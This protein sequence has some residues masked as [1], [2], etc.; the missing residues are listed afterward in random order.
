[1]SSAVTWQKLGMGHAKMTAVRRPHMTF[2]QAAKDDV[3]PA[4]RQEAEIHRRCGKWWPRCWYTITKGK[5]LQSAQQRMRMSY[6][7]KVLYVIVQRS[8]QRLDYIGHQRVP[9]KGVARRN[10]SFQ[11]V[12]KE[13][14]CKKISV[15]FKRF[16]SVSCTTEQIK[17]IEFKAFPCR[18]F[19]TVPNLKK[20]LWLWKCF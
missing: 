16:N 18:F 8:C 6:N 14:S 12:H 19:E 10:F 4:I 5:R 11:W 20:M 17:E 13:R 1:M 9:Q 15:D 3:A 2:L 7:C